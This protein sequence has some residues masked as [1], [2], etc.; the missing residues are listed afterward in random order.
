VIK[1]GSYR[2]ALGGIGQVQEVGFCSGKL[3][4][5]LVIKPSTATNPTTTTKQIIYDIR[6]NLSKC[7]NLEQKTKKND[8][9]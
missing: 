7:L 2:E 3:L 5:Q 6:Y 4:P 9:K 8:Q 1:N